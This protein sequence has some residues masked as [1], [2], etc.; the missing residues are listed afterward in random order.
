LEAQSSSRPD[1]CLPGPWVLTGTIALDADQRA[2]LDSVTRNAAFC[3]TARIIVIGYP[4]TS[5][6]ALDA[7]V[8]RVVR[9]LEYR[10]IDSLR[11]LPRV[12]GA[13]A[14]EPFQGTARRIEIRVAG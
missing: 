4:T 5:D 12:M 8:M 10:G 1:L 14:S 11:L 3:D 6:D 13:P 7:D 9:Y 2:I